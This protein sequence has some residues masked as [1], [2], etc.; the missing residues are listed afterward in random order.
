MGRC[1]SLVLFENEMFLFWFVGFVAIVD[2]ELSVKY[3]TLVNDAPD[4]IKV[5][6]WGKDF[7]VDVFRK[8]D[9]TALQVVSFCT[10]GGFEIIVIILILVDTSRKRH[11]RRDKCEFFLVKFNK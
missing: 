5:L 6:P 4:I 9:F 11:S 3:E 10:G 7:E 8:P 1:V 2:K